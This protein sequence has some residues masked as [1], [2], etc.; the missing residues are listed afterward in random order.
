MGERDSFIQRKTRLVRFLSENPNWTEYQESDELF[1]Q[2]LPKIELHVHLDGSFDPLFLWQ[3]MK[4]N[5]DSLMCFPV[6]TK[7]PWDPENALKIRKMVEECESAEDFH[8]LCTCRGY[9]SLTHMLNCFSIFLPL[10]RR[11]LGLLE[12][13]AF[14]FCQRQWEQNVVYTEVRYSPFLLAESFEKEEG[15]SR[16]D[17]QAVF[18]AITKGLRAGCVKFD[19][20]INQIIS[21]IA[22]GPDWA[23]PS[24]ELVNKHRNDF[25]CATVGIDIASGEEHF[26]AENHKGLH[27]PHFLM[28]QRAMELNIPI[29]LHAGEAS[30]NDSVK[31][32]WQAIDKYGATRI[33]HGYRVINDE[34]LMAEC[35]KRKIHFEVC[36][37]SSDETGGWM[38]ETRRWDDH[39]CLTMR[40]QGLSYSLSSDDPAVFHTSLAWQYRLALVRMGMNRD[41]L[42]QSN[43]NAAEA[44]FAEEDEK[45]RLEEAIKAYADS[46]GNDDDGRRSWRKSV[47]DSFADRVF[48]KQKKGTEKLYF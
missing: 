43:L 17:G 24:V 28:I 19:I 3:Y 45:V 4:N 34:A 33:G 44:S 23:M 8:E 27:E 22:F 6:E 26:D 10:V 39:P 40:N 35:V 5:P 1:V 2:E 20:T 9:R 29:T 32:I 30:T 18:D 25:P 11:N 38:Y 47:S 31:N 36:P 37:T 42:V 13:L 16:V 15:E 46:F 41:D 21:A 7:P 12:Q 14:D 48:V